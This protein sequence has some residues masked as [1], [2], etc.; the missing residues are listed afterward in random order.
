MNPVYILQKFTDWLAQQLDSDDP[1]SPDRSIPDKLVNE[2]IAL[3]REF[4]FPRLCVYAYD[5]DHPSRVAKDALLQ[6]SLL[7]VYNQFNAYSLRRYTSAMDYQGKI[8]YNMD[9]LHGNYPSLKYKLATTPVDRI[10]PWLTYPAIEAILDF[11]LSAYNYYEFGAGMSTLFF[12]FKGCS[13]VSVESD[14]SF[15]QLLRTSSGD[16][17]HKINFFST[18]TEGFDI[19]RRSSSKPSIILVDGDRFSRK[20]TFDFAINWLIQSEA[21][22]IIII[23][24]S[25]IPIYETGFRK[26]YSNK[27]RPITYY[28]TKPGQQY[29][30]CTSICYSHHTQ[31]YNTLA[32]SRHTSIFGVSPF[33]NDPRWMPDTAEGKEWRGE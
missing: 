16:K 28:G 32:P 15:I 30:A 27:L 12:A 9:M 10:L 26:L 3:V 19:L 5:I 7:A 21:P 2:L 6:G 20:P 8:D 4:D 23:D 17:M 31:F 24:D 14:P 11:D 18:V 33:Q 25:D 13:V 1:R 22:S 29:R